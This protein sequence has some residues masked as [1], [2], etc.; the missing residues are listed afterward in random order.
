M[1]G[2]AGTPIFLFL[3]FFFLSILFGQD[4]PY[5]YN[6]IL[7]QNNI[8]EQIKI[9][10]KSLFLYFFLLYSFS[11]ILSLIFFLSIISGQDN[12]YFGVKKN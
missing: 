3:V 6:K 5:F 8:I 10:N 12:P 1:G 7:I 9:K 11:Y 2:V 4:N